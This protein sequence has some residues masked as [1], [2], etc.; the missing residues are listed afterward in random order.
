MVELVDDH[1]IEVSRIDGLDSRL[2]QALDRR[3][4]VVEARW[5][6]AAYPFLTERGIAQGVPEGCAALIK[7]LF[8]VGNEEK[9]RASTARRRRA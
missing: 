1:H 4:H 2:M 8:A 3:K 6:L 9:T 7:D 5:A